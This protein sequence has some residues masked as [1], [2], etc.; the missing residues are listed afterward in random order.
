MA[1]TAAKRILDHPDKDEIISKLI[2][3]EHPD[4]VSIW[5]KDKYS[6]LSESEAK[7]ILSSK[8]L[9]VFTDDY[10]D[11][12]DH[13][14]QDLMKV[15]NLGNDDLDLSIKNN[16]SYQK[17]LETIVNDEVD[18]KLTI[19]KLIAL[20]EGR[21]EQVFDR[22][23]QNPGNMRSDRILIEW[24]N[25]LIAAVDKLDRMVN[26]TP[27][28]IINN[29]VNITYKTIDDNINVVIE[30]I[31]EV[32]S[33]MDIETSLYFM[34]LF[35]EKINKLKEGHKPTTIPVESRLNEVKLLEEKILGFD[36]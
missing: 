25:T 17:R 35:N 19:R 12:Y 23:Q 29:N 24:F 1:S 8:A 36:K 5:L 34:E 3:G 20:I 32:L 9:K 33:K 7:F 22:I 13:I 27:D 14:K 18:L 15:K 31:R 2:A 28:T 4:N 11:L 16:K 30:V 6:G 10:L 21:A 26:N